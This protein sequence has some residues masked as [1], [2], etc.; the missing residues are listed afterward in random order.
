MLK[1]AFY[2]GMM[3]VGI[4]AALISP[5]G[6]AV[7]AISAY[8]TNPAAISFDARYIHYQQYI[9]IAFM[10]GSFIHMRPGLPHKGHEGRVV[11]A[12]WGFIL[13]GYMGSLFAVFSTQDALDALYELFKTMVVATLLLWAIR[14]EKHLR[15]LM[16][17][18]ILGVLHAAFL[19]VLGNRFGFIA[20]QESREYGVLP[21]SQTAVMLLFIPLLLT[22]AGTGKPWERILAFCTLP[23]AID[24]IVNTYQRT[25]F[26]SLIAEVLLVFLLGPRIIIKRVL[27]VAAVGMLLFAFRFTPDNYWAWIG[28]IKAPTEEASANSRLVIDGASLR[29][30]SPCCVKP[31]SLVFASGWARLLDRWSC[32]GGSARRRNTAI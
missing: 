20:G 2:I 9:T 17:T 30:F 18:C 26:V 28:T 10:L 5:C 3:V 6:G 4:I 32:S 16:I 31:V 12:L 22:V 24:S 21:D 19:H 13:V 11:L 8:M 14:T 27:P 29:M 1:S 25:G 23:I 7:A 15:I